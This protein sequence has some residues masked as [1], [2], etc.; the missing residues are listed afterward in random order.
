MLWFTQSTKRCNMFFFLDHKPSLIFLWDS[1]PTGTLERTWNCSPEEA[2]FTISKQNKEPLSL[3]SLFLHNHSKV[4]SQLR[5]TNSINFLFRAVPSLSRHDLLFLWNFLLDYCFIYHC[6]SCVDWC[7]SLV[8]FTT[9]SE[10]TALGCA[11]ACVCVCER[12]VIIH[13]VQGHI[14]KSAPFVL[15]SRIRTILTVKVPSHT[16]S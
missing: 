13:C 2:L 8:S 7:S 9:T 15:G 3:A 16:C 5:T 10:S 12:L 6:F 14:S 1:K 11:R 4:I